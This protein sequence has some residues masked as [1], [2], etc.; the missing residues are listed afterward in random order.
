[1]QFDR[2]EVGI[3]FDL[4]AEE[5]VRVRQELFRTAARSKAI[6]AGA[7]L[8]RLV[9]LEEKGMGYAAVPVL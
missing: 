1:M 7:H 6:L 3:S 9:R 8:P 4:A 5:A 2:P